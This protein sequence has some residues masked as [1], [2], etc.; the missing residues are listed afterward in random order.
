MVFLC[1]ARRCEGAG[2]WAGPLW[3]SFTCYLGR[4][5][6]SAGCRRAPIRLPTPTPPPALVRTPEPSGEGSRGTRGNFWTR[7]PGSDWLG[8]HSPLQQQQRRSM[9]V[10]ELYAQVGARGHICAPARTCGGAEAGSSCQLR[11]GPLWVGTPNGRLL[12]HA[13]WLDHPDPSCCH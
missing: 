8:A 7:W 10:A 2:T 5:N 13:R 3:V 1:S 4:A 11:L 6:G 9:A 12:F